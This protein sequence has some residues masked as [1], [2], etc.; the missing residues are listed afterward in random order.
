MPLKFRPLH[1][2]LLVRRHN[3]DEVTAGGLIIPP[4]AQEDQ[5]KGEVIAAGNGELQEDGSLRPLDVKVGNVVL[6][7]AYAG[8]KVK[9]DGEEYLI[10]R[11]SDVLGVMDA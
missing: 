1:D 9:L 7:G 10:M 6:F 2:R 3:P 11:E 8:T 5:A 4:S